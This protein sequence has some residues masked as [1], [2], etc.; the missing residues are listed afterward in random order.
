MK[1]SR[2]FM[3]RRLFVKRAKE[4]KAPDNALLRKSSDGSLTQHSGAE[5]TFGFIFSDGTVDRHGDTVDPNGWVTDNFVKGGGPLLWAHQYNSPPLGKVTGVETSNGR[6]RGTVEFTPVGMSAFN[7]MIF[8]MT[9]GGF[10]NATSVGFAPKDFDYNEERGG[11]DF[12]SMELLEVSVVPVPANPNALIEAR[13][14]GIDLREL[15][16]WINRSL[17]WVES[18]GSVLVPKAHLEQAAEALGIKMSTWSAPEEIFMSEV[19]VKD[20]EVIEAEVIEDP[21]VE[22]KSEVEL[23]R[24]ELAALK[25]KIEEPFEE[26]KDDDD[27]D[28]GIELEAAPEVVFDISPETLRALVSQALEEVHAPVK[29]AFTNATGQVID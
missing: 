25:A 10:L 28:D 2:T 24:E 15:E 19:E 20:V 16:K 26:D 4:G 6:L 7:D 23:L 8:N 27:D 3:D 14:A 17:E 18:E 9:A 29:A 21:V 5:R 11:I 22:E 13:S 12:K 1:T